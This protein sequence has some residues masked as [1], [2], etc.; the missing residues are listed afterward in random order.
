MDKLNI[1]EKTEFKKECE[2]CGFLET[3]TLENGG[4]VQ[5]E[6][7][8]YQK[9]E[10]KIKLWCEDSRVV[11]KIFCEYYSVC[12]NCGKEKYIG[13]SPTNIYKYSEWK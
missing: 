3:K 8:Y 13:N 6:D 4:I 9:T 12:S 11:Y 7:K 10:Y 5:R 1:T 2:V